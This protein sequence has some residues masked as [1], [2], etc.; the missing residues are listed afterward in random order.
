MVTAEQARQI[1]QEFLDAEAAKTDPKLEQTLKH[2]E[3]VAAIGELH[4]ILF[5]VS[6]RLS[7]NLKALGYQIEYDPDEGGYYVKW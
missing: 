6:P 7:N 1:A 5:S 2:I 4:I 3:T